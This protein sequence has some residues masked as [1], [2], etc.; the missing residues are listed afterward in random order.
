MFCHIT[1][2][3]SLALICIAIHNTQPLPF[4]LRV[5]PRGRAGAGGGGRGGGGGG[6]AGGDTVGVGKGLGVVDC[7]AN[8]R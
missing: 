3:A 1:R 7:N 8:E 2:D 4:C 6:G 5:S